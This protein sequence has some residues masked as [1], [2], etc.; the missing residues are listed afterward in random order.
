VKESGRFVPVLLGCSFLSRYAC[1]GSTFHCV[2]PV[3]LFW[4]HLF[5]VD[6]LN[7]STGAHSLI[8]VFFLSL[9]FL[10]YNRLPVFRD[11][12]AFVLRTSL[13]Y[14]SDRNRL[15]D[16]ILFLF[17]PSPFCES[18]YSPAPVSIPLPDPLNFP[19][20]MCN[21]RRSD[22]RLAHRRV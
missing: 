19:M 20:R 10:R 18:L 6:V 11:S 16:C 5:P 8:R 9:S 2:P 15:E 7:G 1:P 3:F 13:L 22:R 14:L 21:H 4:S 12:S 17:F